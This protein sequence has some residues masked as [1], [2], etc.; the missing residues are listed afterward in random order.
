M[1]DA[2]PGFVED[3]VFDVFR[4]SHIPCSQVS[5][6]QTTPVEMQGVSMG[7]PQSDEHLE[8]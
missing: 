2:C 1:L 6:T 5:A 8:T 4:T 7:S 3:K